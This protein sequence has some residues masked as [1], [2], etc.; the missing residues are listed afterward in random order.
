MVAAQRGTGC[1]RAERKGFIPTAG[2]TPCSSS[3]V[4]AMPRCIPTPVGNTVRPCQPWSHRPVHPHARGEHLPRL[5]LTHVSNGPSPRTWGT[6]SS[7]RRGGCVGRFIPTHVGNT[8][9]VDGV[10]AR[11][12]VHPHARGE[13]AEHPHTSFPIP[14]SSPRTWGTRGA[15][16]L[17][18]LEPR[19][20]PTHVGNT[21]MARLPARPRSV[22]P[23]ARGEH[24]T[25]Q[26]TSGNH[27]RFIPTH[28]GNTRPRSRWPWCS[29]VHP[30]ARG[31]HLAAMCS[32]KVRYGSSPR[33]WGTHQREASPRS[34]GRFIP[35]HVG[36]TTTWCCPMGR[37][38]VHPHARGEHSAP[39]M[40]RPCS[41]GS[42]PR[43]WGTPL[44]GQLHRTSLRFIPTHVGNTRPRP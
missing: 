35:T 32:G 21:R 18:A 16:G 41:F 8:C 9:D 29:A 13:H 22:H 7:F 20:I 5:P 40:I 19:F 12:A 23:H 36:N 3:L 39:P 4:V 34:E 11:A 30:H 42:S 2:G 15:R 43:T 6:L 33:T 28:V 31:E 10:S 26:R 27:V 1:R 25:I 38:A 17:L 24:P 37:V 14:G 44:A